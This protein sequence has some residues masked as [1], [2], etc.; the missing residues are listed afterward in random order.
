VKKSLLDRWFELS[1]AHKA[2]STAN[3]KAAVIFE[4]TDREDYRATWD[5]LTAVDEALEQIR[6][7]KRAS[8]EEVEAA[9]A[10]FQAIVQRC[11]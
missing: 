2:I 4:T 8:D 3:A 11:L 9:F 5:E 7:G 1:L 10:H 6:S